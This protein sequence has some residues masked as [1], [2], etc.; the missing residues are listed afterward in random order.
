MS[1]SICTSCLARLQIGRLTWLARASPAPNS[2]FHSSASQQNVVKK[3]TNTAVSR[4]PKLRESR[5]AR[6]VRK[7]KDRP[8]PP[9]VG[10]RAMERRRIILSNTNAL[11][12]EDMEKLTP[13]NMADESKAGNVLA[14]DGPVLDQLREAKAFKTTQN[15]NLFR[16]PS[17]LQRHESVQIGADINA[18]NESGKTCHRLVTG[19]KASGKSVHLLQ[20]MSMAYL[21]KWIVINV[22]DGKDFLTSSFATMLTIPQ[23]RNMLSISLL[24]HLHLETTATKHQSCMS[25]LS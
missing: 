20:A 2:S 8:K 15:W 6:I 23:A 3:K 25:S 14:L 1:T 17:T 4:A 18:V 16:N 5:S 13:T 24:M 12:L 19:N 7:R 22:P 10:Q 21:N 9:P 11:E